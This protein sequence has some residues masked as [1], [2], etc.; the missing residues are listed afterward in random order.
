MYSYICLFV[1]LSHPLCLS[2]KAF[3]VFCKLCTFF[4]NLWFLWN[5]TDVSIF[6]YFSIYFLCYVNSTR[7]FKVCL[8]ALWK[9]THMSNSSGLATHNFMN[10]HA[11]R[12]VDSPPLLRFFKAKKIAFEFKSVKKAE[13]NQIAGEITAKLTSTFKNVGTFSSAYLIRRFSP[14]KTTE[15]YWLICSRSEPL[16]SAWDHYFFAFAQTITWISNSSC[17]IFTK[18]G[19]GSYL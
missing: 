19:S 17:P 11:K 18:V 16:V 15:I 14:T 5:D 4:M 6:F 7:C 9:A 12:K 13:S 8:Y 1:V 3:I 2:L 10:T